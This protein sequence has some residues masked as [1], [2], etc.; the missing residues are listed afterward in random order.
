ML[1]PL[2]ALGPEIL[3]AYPEATL[4]VEYLRHFGA[5]IDTIV[6]FGSGSGYRTLS[7]A[8]HLK[9]SK[10][11]GIEKDPSTVTTAT[12]SIVRGKLP[13]LNGHLH[14]IRELVEESG[15]IE[16][17]TFKFRT[18]ALGFIDIFNPVPAVE[19]RHGDMCEGVASTELEEGLFDLSHCR[20]V[21][22]HMLCEEPPDIDLA[23]KAIK[24]MSRVVKPGGHILV[25]EPITCPN[26]TT[27]INELTT[28]LAEEASPT[29][30]CY[31]PEA[32][33]AHFLLCKNE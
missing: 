13:Q 27:T 22:Y 26:E 9:A 7:L 2:R 4:L 16:E 30:V 1:S 23:R 17:L 29:Y 14:K 11:I 33:L 6:D 18:E 10:I 20:Y 25:V 5:N 21:L 12:Q 32:G 24:E 3:N 15:R 31:S 28:L 8:I 19:F